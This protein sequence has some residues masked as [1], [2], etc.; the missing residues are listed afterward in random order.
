MREALARLRRDPASAASDAAAP[1]PALRQVGAIPCRF[2]G[3]ELQ[4]LLVTSRRTGRWI[5]PKGN[6][7]PGES[8][9]RAAAREAYEEAGVSGAIADAPIGAYRTRRVRARTEL[10]EV[11]MYVLIVSDEHET[12]PERGERKRRWVTLDQARRMIRTP[13]LLRLAEQAE[14]RFL[15]LAA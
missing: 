14:R 8:A 15:S 3:G 9:G 10:A 5:F 11:E 7:D 1:A 4:L 12:W 13:G 6:L 2:A